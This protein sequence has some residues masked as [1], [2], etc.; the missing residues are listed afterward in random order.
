MKRWC[1]LHEV[2]GFT[3]KEPHYNVKKDTPLVNKV[4]RDLATASA[5]V[6]L[7][8]GK[9][10]NNCIF[11]EKSHPSEK[12]FTAKKMS[13]D[14]KRKVLIKKGAC[15]SCL[16]RANHLSKFCNFKRKLKC[17]LCNNNGNNS[18][19]EIM[20]PKQEKE[21]I[22]KADNSLSNCSRSECVVLQTLYVFFRCQGLIPAVLKFF[23]N[24]RYVD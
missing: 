15:F 4:N 9:R 24:K 19:F 20:C 16:K 6:S 14:D 23:Q 5:L 1:C 7:D 21:I 13:L 11:C 22:C 12:C 8:S 2:G 18:H 10:F 17:S 3:P